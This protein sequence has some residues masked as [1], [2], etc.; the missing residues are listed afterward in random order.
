MKYT[1][2]GLD[3]KL[4]CEW[5]IDLKD[6]LILRYVIDFCESPRMIKK[7]L[8]DGAEYTW[9]K[10][11]NLIEEFP[12][13]GFGN[14]AKTTNPKKKTKNARRMLWSKLQNLIA[15]GVLEHHQDRQGGTYSYFRLTPK[16][17]LLRRISDRQAL[18]LNKASH[19]TSGSPPPLTIESKGFSLQ[20]QKAFDCGVKTKYPLTNINNK[21]DNNTRGACAP[22]NIESNSS[23]ESKN[24]YEDIEQ[25]FI[26]SYRE[27]TGGKD[28]EFNYGAVRKRVKD[29]LKRHTVEEIKQIITAAKDDEW[30]RENRAFDLMTILSSRVLNKLQQKVRGSPLEKKKS[31]RICPICDI[32]LIGPRFTCPVCELP[33]KDFTNPKA[34][35]KYKE[36]LKAEDDETSFAFASYEAMYAYEE[37]HPEDNG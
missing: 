7:K 34:V 24:N 12:I 37:K 3:Q 9:I 8:D 13:L 30:I 4:M 35:E 21:L 27:I 36:R 18:Q 10:Y 25:H 6:A 23:K 5:G 17:E 11:E 19:P 1:I 16:C 32:E 29:L 28:P 33:V 2:F 22:S 15:K 20:S 26:N 31:P 14:N